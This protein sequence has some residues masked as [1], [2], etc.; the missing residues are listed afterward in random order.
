MCIIIH[1]E[2]QCALIR[3][4]LIIFFLP[5]SYVD[6]DA[7]VSKVSYYKSMEPAYLEQVATYIATETAGLTYRDWSLYMNFF[8]R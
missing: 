2:I 8:F 7:G 4:C 5:H 1:G 3:Q 6:L